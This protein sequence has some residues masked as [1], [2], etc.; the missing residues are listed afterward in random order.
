MRAGGAGFGTENSPGAEGDQQV[1]AIESVESNSASPRDVS[2]VLKC[3]LTTSAR[4][5]MSLYPFAGAHAVQSVAFGFEWTNELSDA[6]LSAV[7]GA[8]LAQ[9]RPSLPVAASTQSMVVQIESGGVA[10]MNTSAQGGWRYSKPGHGGMA[11]LLDVQRNRCVGQFNDYTRWDPVFKE[12][13]KWF[14]AVGPNLGSRQYASLGLEYTDVFNWRADPQ[15]LNVAEVFRT[16]SPYLPSNVFR[17]KSLW[18]SH[19]GFL[20]DRTAPGVENKL[21]ENINVNLIEELGQRSIVITTVHRASFVDVWGWEALNPLLVPM[22]EDFHARNKQ[23]LSDLLTN[24]VLD[25][26]SL[27]GKA[28]GE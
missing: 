24:E 11:R 6:E 13:K 4:L 19:H 3:L 15:S 25:K 18:H 8:Y 14:D 23:T 12:A 26:I 22:F 9:L 10:S 21:L 28:K 2:D 16:D 27:N 5:P 17:Q 1:L 7:N 20:S